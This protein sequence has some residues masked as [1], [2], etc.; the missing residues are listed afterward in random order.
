MREDK[1]AILLVSS[2][3]DEILSLSDSIIVMHEGE[4]AK[5]E[6]GLYMLGVKK[7]D[8]KIIGGAYYE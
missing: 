2:D 1:K 7:D 6:L 3:L 4:I 8:K 5:E